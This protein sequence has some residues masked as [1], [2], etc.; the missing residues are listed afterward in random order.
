MSTRTQLWSRFVVGMAWLAIMAVGVS[1]M[2]GQSFFGAYL[3][4]LCSAL[5]ASAVALAWLIRWASKEENRERQFGLGSLFFFVT[6]LAICFAGM[7]AILR[8]MA[9]HETAGLP[10][11]TRQPPAWLIVPLGIYCLVLI[12][13]SVPFVMGIVEALMWFAVWL[14]RRPTTHR[15]VRWLLLRRRDS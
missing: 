8:G 15:V 5:F 9:V 14:V 11:G 13:I 2:T 6:L 7:S 1:L 12:L 4:V 10:A 3:A